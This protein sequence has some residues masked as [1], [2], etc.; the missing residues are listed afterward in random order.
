MNDLP[1]PFMIRAHVPHW[2]AS[3]ADYGAASQAARRGLPS[4]LNVSYGEHADEKLDLFFPHDVRAGLAVRPIHMFVHGGY[5]RSFSKDDYSFVADSVTA[6]GAIAVIVDYSLLP[7]ARMA[8]LVDQ[9]RRAARWLSGHAGEFGGDPTAIS[10]SGH[11]AGAHL[12]S[13]LV[14]CG[15]Q[16]PAREPSPVR[17]VLLVSGI[18]DLAPLIRSFLQPEVH[19]T[20]EEVAR[21]S[22]AT[23]RPRAEADVRIVVGA[24]ETPPFLEQAQELSDRLREARS[25]VAHSVIPS[26]DH[27]TIVRELGRPGTP[28]AALLKETIAASSGAH[29]RLSP[30]SGSGPV[31]V[32]H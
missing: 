30:P 13:Y 10:A 22:P 17:S 20:D 16:E 24:R 26:E 4:R 14:C 32:D 19:L 8:T 18:Y 15:P 11:S 2:E 3:V 28:C 9:V 31:R 29:G 7:G 12:A 23:A 27:M 5:W 6:L 1:D 21:W 25:R